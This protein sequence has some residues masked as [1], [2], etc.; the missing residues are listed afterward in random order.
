MSI[1]NWPGGFIQPIPPTPAGPFQ[2]GAAPG[3][4]TLDQVAYWT[5]QGLWPIAGSGTAPI[6]LF[7]GSSSGSNVIDKITIPTTGNSTDFGDLNYD[8]KDYPGSCASNTRGLFAGGYDGSSIGYV[9]F[10]TSGNTSNFGNLTA[11][12]SALTSNCGNQ[13]RGLFCGG[14]TGSSNTSSNIIDYVTI[15]TTGNATDYGD[16]IPATR[17]AGGCSSTTRS[18]IGGGDPQD[19]AIRTTNV[20]QYVTIATTGNATDFGD[21]VSAISAITACSNNTRGVFAGGFDTGQTNVIQYITIASTGNSTDFGDL[22]SVA[23]ALAGCSSSTRGVFAGGGN[24]IQYITIA[25]AGNSTDF[26]DLTRSATG[27]GGCSNAHG[28]L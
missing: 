4:W 1:K 2:D 25:S 16:L 15:A 23:Q 18:V 5:Q 13:T 14:Y 24:V 22:L 12:R 6:G 27:M 8:P 28:G 19:G 7:A 3:V 26:G 17:L 9:T 10:S 20:I 11:N 21:L